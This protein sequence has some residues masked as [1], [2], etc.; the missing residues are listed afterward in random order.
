M[1]EW[2]TELIRTLIVED[3]V[4]FAEAL[5]KGLASEG[6]QVF[7]VSDASSALNFLR[8]KL[9][10]VA[11]ID[12]RL[13]DIDGISLLK[14]VKDVQSSCEVIILTGYANIDSAVRAM[15]LGAYDYLTKPCLFSDLLMTVIR[16]YERK[17]LT[18]ANVRLREQLSKIKGETELI[19]SSEAIG[20]IRKLISLVASSD[21]PVLIEGETG[22]GKEVVA[23]AIHGQSPRRSEAFV[24]INAG[25]LP[26]SML[27]SE[28]FGFRKG[29][30]TGAHSDKVG[31]L[32]VAHK[33]T[34]FI[35]EVADMNLNVQAKMLRVLETGSFRKLGDTREISVD[36]R[37]IFATNKPL[38]GEVAAGRFREDLYYRINTFI[39]KIP[40][41]RERREDIPL[42]VDHFLR[43]AGQGRKRVS[44]EALE[45][46]IRY[47]WP[48]NVRELRN[49]LE[50]AL[51]LTEGELI[52][53]GALP[54]NV[55][56]GNPGEAREEIAQEGPT[57]EQIERRYIERMLSQTNGNKSRA[58]R[59]LG[60]SRRKLYRKLRKYGLLQG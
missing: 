37:F 10:D 18:E 55:V 35:D 32:E 60:I 54:S 44:K 7:S 36:V 34:C 31:L 3:D 48:G 42:L 40:P 20:R 51:L 33:G 21:V 56:S 6:I 16:A 30:F 59:I 50:R 25:T 38:E 23:R 27:E 53:I 14:K 41:L 8:E 58:A 12:I 5:A 11:I 24:V 13:P 22:T 17:S 57:L 39:I 52:D 45:A 2:N 46:L 28:M 49:V 1:K 9:V 19:G 26:E 29:C 15:K 4:D 43:K 47:H